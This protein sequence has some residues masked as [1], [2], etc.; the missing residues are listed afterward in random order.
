MTIRP[1]TIDDYEQL[2]RLW[3]KTEGM[4][5]RSLDDSRK[6]IE[7][8]LERNRGISFLS[9]EEGLITGAILCGHDGRRAYIY[10]AAID[11]RFRGR[12][13]GRKL[14]ER[15]LNALK[16]EGI[17]KAALV[18]YTENTE[19]NS[20]WETMGFTQREDLVYRNLSLSPENN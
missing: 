10:H 6:G 12:G 3:T 5:L 14:V 13:L 18:V 17:H 1:V 4:G 7:R 8:F 9:T 19:G 11:S 20:F 15:T 16:K 2:I